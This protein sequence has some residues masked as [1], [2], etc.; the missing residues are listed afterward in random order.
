[1][2]NVCGSVHEVKA[3]DKLDVLDIVCQ[4]LQDRGVPIERTSVSGI[5]RTSFKLV[6]V[7]VTSGILF[8]TFVA[9][10]V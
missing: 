1:M 5:K 7:D 4:R 3:I 9:L 10:K 2:L 6:T 8:W